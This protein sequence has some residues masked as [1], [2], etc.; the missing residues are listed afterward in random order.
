MKEHTISIIH[1]KCEIRQ[2]SRA[3]ITTLH[4]QEA[5]GSLGIT[6][7]LDLKRKENWD[8]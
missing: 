6:T 2:L 5:P 1:N 4:N 7:W 3:M 8:L